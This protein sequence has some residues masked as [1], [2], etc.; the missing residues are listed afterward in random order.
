MTDEEIITALEIDVKRLKVEFDR[1]LSGSSVLPPEQFRKRIQDRIQQLRG[2]HLKVLAHR[3]R[4]NTLEANFNTITVLFNRQMRDRETSQRRKFRSL[5]KET[6]PA[7]AQ[8]AQE[9]AVPTGASP[10]EIRSLFEQYNAKCDP[11]SKTDYPHFEVFVKRQFE[12]I[13]ERTGCR[14]V[15]FR[16]ADEEGKIKLKAKPV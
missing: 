11:G 13:R 12:S 3:F 15:K 2:H 16:I 9:A 7:E 10:E 8:T 14:G 4:V 6:P 5:G 1:F